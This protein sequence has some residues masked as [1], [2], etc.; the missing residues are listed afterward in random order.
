[1][2]LHSIQSSLSLITIIEVGSL[3]I[4]KTSINK[5]SQKRKNEIAFNNKSLCRHT[6]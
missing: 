1:M 4:V 6:L 5:A 3:S 2:F